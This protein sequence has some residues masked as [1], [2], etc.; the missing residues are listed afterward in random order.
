[1]NGIRS[2]PLAKEVR[3]HGLVRQ[4]PYGLF[5]LLLPFA[6]AAGANPGHP[7]PE[8]APCADVGSADVRRAVRPGLGTAPNRRPD[9]NAT[10]TGARGREQLTHSRDWRALPFCRR[11]RSGPSILSPRTKLAR[12]PLSAIAVSAHD[13]LLLVISTPER[14]RIEC[15]RGRGRARRSSHHR[16][17]GR[18]RSA[19]EDRT[20]LHS[21]RHAAG[22][23]SKLSHGVSPTGIGDRSGLVESRN[24]SGQQSDRP[25]TSQNVW[26]ERRESNPR[27]QLGKLMYCLCTTLAGRVGFATQC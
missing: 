26:S 19:S 14:G 2:R 12:S 5:P 11:R 10:A 1:M 16:R 3:G 24:P 22:Q 7:R 8:A 18:D 17:L 25:L 4:A 6:N 9:V 20:R 15:E 21:S 27:S 23:R 13:S